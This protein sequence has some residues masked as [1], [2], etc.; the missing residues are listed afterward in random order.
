MN[1]MESSPTF[2]AYGIFVLLFFSLTTLRWGKKI[3]GNGVWVIWLGILALLG[4]V[5]LDS[6]LFL[7]EAFRIKIWKMGWIWPKNEISAITVG[8]YQDALSL[9][10]S[11][12]AALIAGVFLANQKGMSQKDYSERASAAVAI[13]TAG[14]ALAW[15]S[16]TPWLSFAG[17]V[18]TFV[19]GFIALVARCDTNLDANFAARFIW[20]RSSG[21]L[22]AFF[23]TCILATSRSALLLNEF[24]SWNIGSS[25][26][27]STWIGFGLLVTGLFVQMQP[28]PLFGWV[29]SQSAIPSPLRVLLNQI[30]PSWAA[31]SLLIRI[32]PQ[33]Q[34]LGLF[35]G[36]GWVALVSAILIFFSGLFQ[37]QWQLGLGSWLAGGFSLSCAFLAFAGPL[38]S[39]SLMIGI[40]L[41]ALIISGGAMALDVSCKAIP[42]YQRRGSWI[43][44]AIF[45]AGASGTGMIGFVSVA[46]GLRWIVSGMSL[47]GMAALFAFVFFIFVLLGWKLVWQIMEK[48]RFSDASWA[49]ILSLLGWFS[50]STGVV[51]TGSVTSGVLSV[52]PDRMGPSLFDLFF[53]IHGIDFES[54]SDFLSASGLYWGVWVGAFLTAYWSTGR[55]EDRWLRLGISFP[56]TNQFI[57]SGY[58]VDDLVRKLAQL[59]YWV[60]D[61]A[62]AWVDQKIGCGLSNGFSTLI[63]VV[64]EKVNRFDLKLTALLEGVLRRLI[65]V[66]AKFLQLI[67][68]GD[69]RWYLF[70]GLGSGLALISHFLKA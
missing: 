18:M 49:S 1:S 3:P 13:S 40:S 9:T 63:K 53:G 41:A 6:G 55:G 16:L 65:E 8:L 24:E 28:I 32:F 19:G 42:T 70:F 35:P 52:H 27:F 38:A 67:H 68:T 30:F 61:W 43:K 46:G 14:V 7:E 15:S 64:S 56:R 59:L 21:F 17:L 48:R 23:G 29:V 54:N 44:S 22:I 12:L 4:G 36:L 11:A 66:P 5:G 47:N 39:M 33:L 51:W 57:V 31:F 34:K 37:K 50:L 25:S 62:E 69:I 10:M 58:G 20:E 26:P 60:G 2:L 45:L